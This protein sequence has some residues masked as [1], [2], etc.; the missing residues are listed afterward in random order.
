MI[1]LKN[2]TEKELKNIL[3][4]IK[5]KA[6]QKAK[7]ENDLRKDFFQKVK[8]DL[9][10]LKKTSEYD[11]I[12]DFKEIN[13]PTHSEN[14]FNTRRESLI[15]REV[16]K[17]FYHNISNYTVDNFVSNFQ[18]QFKNIEIKNNK[19]KFNINILDRWGDITAHRINQFFTFFNTISGIK[20][21]KWEYELYNSFNEFNK[22]Y[23][24]ND[25]ISFKVYKN[26]KIELIINE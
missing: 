15:L 20:I 13:I 8:K 11:Y 10:E 22:I 26:G 2:F 21:P 24:L 18:H 16:Q 4:E 19:I 7:F 25:N 23:T 3:E 17:Y 1:E 14:Y 9:E 5:E 6:T 12:I